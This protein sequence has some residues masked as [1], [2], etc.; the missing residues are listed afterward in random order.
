MEQAA[1][2]ALRLFFRRSQATTTRERTSAIEAAITLTSIS[3]STSSPHSRGGGGHLRGFDYA[4]QLLLDQAKALYRY[5]P[6]V[7]VGDRLFA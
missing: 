6:E 4:A 1:R 2:R 5:W 7:E 3:T